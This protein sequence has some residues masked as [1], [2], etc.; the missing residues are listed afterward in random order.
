MKRIRLLIFLLFVAASTQAQKP[1][2]KEFWLSESGTPIKVNDLLYASNNYLWLATDNGVFRFNGSDFTEI[3]DTIH[4]PV[5]AI[6]EVNGVIYAGYKNGRIGIVNNEVSLVKIKH[7][8]P[9]S[10]I[11]SLHGSAGLLYVTTED[12]GLFIIINGAGLQ[13]STEKGLIDN[14][15]YDA[16]I[17]NNEAMIATDR[18]I[19]HIRWKNGSPLVNVLSTTQGLPDNIVR[20]LQR[21]PR[22]ELCWIGTQEGGI[23]L[24]DNANKTFLELR[25]SSPWIWGQVNDILPLSKTETW[26]VT[27]GGYLLHAIYRS[28]SLHIVAFAY[29]DVKLNRLVNDKSGNI[30]CATNKGLLMNTALY[31][32]HIALPSYYQ[33]KNV[34]AI[35]CDN[36]NNLWFTQNNSLYKFSINQKNVPELVLKTEASITCLYPDGNGN[37]WIGT[38]GGGLFFFRDGKLISQKNIAT[39]TD[40]HILSIAAIKDHL[41]IASLNGVEEALMES[42]SGSLKIVKHHNKLSGTGSDYIYQLYPDSK[43]NMW[44]ATDGG[45]VCKYDGEKYERWNESSGFGSN[46]VYSITEDANGNMWAGTLEKGLFRLQGNKW[47]QFT[48]TEGLQNLNVYALQGTATGEVVIVNEDGIDEWYPQSKQFRH[49][50]R[51]LGIDIDSTL[52]IPN[53]IAKDKVGNVYVPFEHGVIIFGAQS[54]GYDVTPA[55]NITA[56]SLF[57]K[58]LPSDQ[59]IFKHKENHI[60]FHFD[61]INFSNPERLHYRYKLDNFDPNWV[62]TN[63]EVIPFVQLPAGDFTFHVQASLSTNFINAPEV[64]YSFSVAKPYWQHTWF[65][66]LMALALF[67]AGYGYIK[68]REKNLRK[69]SLLQKER[70]IFEYEHLKSQVNPHF[71]FNS[72][73]TLVSLIEEDKNAAAD[74]TVHLSD[75]YRN[76]LSFKDQDLI[77]LVEEY[78]IIKNYMYIQKSRFGE[79]LHL[80]ADIPEHLLQTKKIVP[81][82]LQLLVEN[83]IKHN[84]VSLSKPLTISIIADENQIVVSN[85]LQPKISKEKG[86]GLGLMNIKKR[87]RL[88]TNRSIKFGI[89]KEEYTVILPLL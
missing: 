49:F 16:L 63:D 48:K 28:D 29:P 15:A 74:Y 4:Q 50:N 75:L 18:G 82:A 89:E 65:I 73:N 1:F 11:T 88:L 24:Y 36:E 30:W 31:A 19:N 26:I 85:R 77:G 54:G 79:A 86:A 32:T 80:Q 17:R 60:S 57:N 38:F 62:Y 22:T 40:G 47:E 37:L 76:M 42:T 2:A 34:T 84:I 5:T 70:M 27:E 51:R 25:N 44:M 46:V 41:W 13:F 58:P 10:S 83:A 68:L 87:Y 52:A 6:A 56:I 59:H 67:G 61:G 72:L 20:V 69:M 45:G 64:T 43:G 81:L 35:S 3:A 53:C 33:L 12:E 71:L 8:V 23:A 14:F 66:T 7:Q 9:I 39:L 78:Q 55:I 21:I